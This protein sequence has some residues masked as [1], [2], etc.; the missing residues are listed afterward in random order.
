MLQENLLT[1]KFNVKVQ[2]T[3]RP[4][5]NGSVEAATPCQRAVSLHYYSCFRD[6]GKNIA[7]TTD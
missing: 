4:Q 2:P 7:Q 1:K 5:Q 3:R 6:Y